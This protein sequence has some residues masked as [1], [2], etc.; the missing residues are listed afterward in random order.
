MDTLLAELSYKDIFTLNDAYTLRNYISRKNPFMSQESSSRVFADAV[1]RIVDRKLPR[2]EDE[3]RRRLKEMLFRDAICKPSFTIDCSD[4]FKAAIKSG[5]LGNWF[6]REMADWVGEILG[7]PVEKENLFR[8]V[9]DT[10]KMMSENPDIGVDQILEAIDRD[11]SVGIQTVEAGIIQANEDDIPTP[12][13]KIIEVPIA[14]NVDVND[15]NTCILDSIE[16]DE[17]KNLNDKL[18]E[19]TAAI[20]EYVAITVDKDVNLE[21]SLLER[22]KLLLYSNTTS[23]FKAGKA[24]VLAGFAGLI[25]SSMLPMESEWLN[26][27]NSKTESKYSGTY[28]L[29]E[30]YTEIN[31]SLKYNGID[32]QSL[33]LFDNQP[34][35][36]K[37]KR[38]RAT[39][40]DLSV[41]S[42]G[43]LPGEPGYGITCSGTRATVG[44][45]VAVDPDIIPLGSKLYI[46][47]PDKYKSMNGIYYAEDTGRLIK[48]YKVDI[49]FGEDKKDSSLIN[50]KAMEFGVQNVDIQIID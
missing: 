40:Y 6:F 24:I 15:E 19:A 9:I 37:V 25:I 33:V 38:M 44:R 22:L 17:S 29:S 36:N 46:R 43:K 11:I 48:G 3:Q 47:F 16:Y 49:F 35:I 5:S 32:V 21:I 34:D 27:R 30:Q 13:D 7:K 12:V 14:I 1:I 42:C 4:V 45:T 31:D 41:E 39:A 10:R 26:I 50:K 18:H 20:P 2:L 8:L 23:R 28:S